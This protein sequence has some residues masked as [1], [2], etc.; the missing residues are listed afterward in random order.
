MNCINYKYWLI[1]ND[2]N[3]ILYFYNL[4][5]N[6]IF[7]KKEINANIHNITIVNNKIVLLTSY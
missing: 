4:I 2:N 6:K 5:N 1:F 7:K 3:N